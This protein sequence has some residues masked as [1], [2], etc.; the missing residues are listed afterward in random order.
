MAQRP[1]SP[2]LKPWVT[3]PAA[4]AINQDVPFLSSL[5]EVQSDFPGTLSPLGRAES[6][7]TAVLKV[8]CYTSLRQ[9]DTSCPNLAAL[10]ESAW[11]T[12]VAGGAQKLGP[13]PSTR[14]FRIECWAAAGANSPTRLH[15]GPAPLCP[16]HPPRRPKTETVGVWRGHRQ[17]CGAPEGT[18]AGAAPRA[19]A[20][21]PGSSGHVGTCRSRAA[22]PGLG[23]D[24]KFRK[25][26]TGL[27]RRL[28]SGAE[29]FIFLLLPRG[30]LHST[31]FIRFDISPHTAFVKMEK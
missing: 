31:S 25:G 24:R 5:S 4:Q 6:Q 16:A 20:D 17:A 1:V 8:S 11:S 2:D 12:H 14:L 7:E 29:S 13:I 15:P 9:T 3:L 27:S 18:R 19:A 22:G 10:G 23:K 21:S 30:Q 28:R 26:K